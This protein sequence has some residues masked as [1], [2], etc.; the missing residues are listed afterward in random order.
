MTVSLSIIF[1]HPKG[2]LL[3]GSP[4]GVQDLFKISSKQLCAGDPAG[5]TGGCSVMILIL[6]VETVYK[7]LCLEVA[8]DLYYDSIV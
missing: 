8:S 6:F 1:P 7:D 5:V 3:E 4:A 2:S